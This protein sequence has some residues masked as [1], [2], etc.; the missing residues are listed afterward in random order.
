MLTKHTV[1]IVR[2][3]AYFVMYTGEHH[4]NCYTLQIKLI[5]RFR[6]YCGKLSDLKKTYAATFPRVYVHHKVLKSVHFA[7]SYSNYKQAFYGD[8]V[9]DEF[10]T[11]KPQKYTGWPKKVSHYRESSLNRIKNR[12]PG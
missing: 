7:P 2:I 12:Q 3:Y 10:V 9:D 5:L 1:D 6:K 8:S 4:S 11:E